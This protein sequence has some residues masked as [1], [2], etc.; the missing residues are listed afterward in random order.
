MHVIQ[1]CS[2]CASTHDRFT[3]NTQRLAAESTTHVPP[4]R[5]LH[6]ISKVDRAL[7]FWAARLKAGQ[8]RSFLLLGQ[9]PTLLPARHPC[10]CHQE[11]GQA[12]PSERHRS[13]RAQGMLLKSATLH[14]L[15]L[16]VGLPYIGIKNSQTLKGR[17]HDL[18][19]MLYLPEHDLRAVSCRMGLAALQKPQ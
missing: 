11:S 16:V 3:E 7:G 13:D 10:R 4:C 9:G 14:Q 5:L 2:C 17:P 1:W 18:Q 6:D 12:Q 8:H 19:Q 15:V